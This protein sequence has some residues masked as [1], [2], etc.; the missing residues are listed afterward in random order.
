MDVAVM[1][2]RNNLFSMLGWIIVFAGMGVFLFA[3][4][5]E[6]EKTTV[7]KVFETVCC[8]AA[9]ILFEVGNSKKE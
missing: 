3:F 9:L 1:K 6:K 4:L 7:V 8:F 5:F 2:R